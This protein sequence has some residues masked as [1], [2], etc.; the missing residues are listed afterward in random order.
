MTTTTFSTALVNSTDAD[1]RVW[2]KEFSD[3]LLAIGLTKTSD[4][5]QIDFLTA[6]R[7]TGGYEIWRFNDTMQGTRPLF[8]KF[9]YRGRAAFTADPEMTLEVGTGSNGS[10]TITGV[11]FEEACLKDP[12][13]A[14]SGVAAPSYFCYVDGFLGI[15]FKTGVI[16]NTFA[17]FVGLFISR[18]VDDLGVANGDGVCV[19]SAGSSGSPTLGAMTEGLGAVAAYDLGMRCWSFL[20]GAKTAGTSSTR[21]RAS[22]FVTGTL[23]VTLVGAAAQVFKHYMV[24]PRVRPNLFVLSA[25]KTEVPDNSSFSINVVG[26]T[27]RNYL[28]LHGGSMRPV[29]ND[30]GAGTGNYAICMLW[31]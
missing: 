4:T 31:E 26:A 15:V 14:P 10:G 24:M 20:T 29:F 22:S 28:C 13:N 18:S 8:L 17:T 27:A 1:F 5:G 25:R 23:G 11:L 30:V 2:A 16:P 21:S 12:A 6:V 7:S 9:K 3:A 19:L